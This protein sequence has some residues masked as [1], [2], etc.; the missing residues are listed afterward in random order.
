MFELCTQLN[1]NNEGISKGNKNNDIEEI[2]SFKN[3]FNGDKDEGLEESIKEH[4]ERELNEENDEKKVPMGKY[5]IDLKKG[6]FS[7]H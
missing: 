5:Y 4:N 6:Y 1:Y 7:F 3:L 2:D